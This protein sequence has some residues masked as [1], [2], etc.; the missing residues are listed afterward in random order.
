MAQRPGSGHTF[1]H[2]QQQTQNELREY[3]GNY[4]PEAC[5]RFPLVPEVVGQSRSQRVDETKRFEAYQPSASVAKLVD[6]ADL[7][8]VRRK[9]VR[10]RLPPLAPALP[11]S[12]FITPARTS[13]S[14]RYHEPPGVG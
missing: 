13:A 3:S 11:R 14:A 4:P 8:S 6:A 2:R 9:A 5:S 1:R 7:K 12:M 10:V